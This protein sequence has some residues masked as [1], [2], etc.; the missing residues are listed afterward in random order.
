[1]PKTKILS[2]I[3]NS[4]FFIFLL[5]CQ[6]CANEESDK[7]IDQQDFGNFYPKLDFQKSAQI[8]IPTTSTFAHPSSGQPVLA[9][10]A[11]K[12]EN[13]VDDIPEF[14]VLFEGQ[15][16]LVDENGFFTFSINDPDLQ[17]YRLIITRKIQHIVNKKNTFTNLNV[18]PNKNYLCY[19][20][21]KLGH[22]QG[23][24]LQKE[25]KLNRKNFVV[26]KN[27]IIVLIDPKYVE[28][29]ED[30]NISLAENFIQLPR[31]VLK[32]TIK[33]NK[34]KRISAKSLLCLENS[35]FHERSGR[36]YK[37]SEVKNNK[38]KVTLP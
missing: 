7:K 26:P 24:W 36:V 37:S 38:V 15:E 4:I 3:T 5:M 28:K 25:R 1:M 11:I 30:W 22:D 23:I 19:S 12:I 34:L 29:I 6:I 20:F 21:K 33:T 35:L 27:S 2:F 31:I 14:R 9:K 13:F 16:T 17:K 8:E 10:G 32:S 18:I